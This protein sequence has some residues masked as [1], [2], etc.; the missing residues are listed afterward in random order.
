[1][2]RDILF[3]MCISVLCLCECADT[4]DVVSSLLDSV[5]L[6]CSV[7]SDNFVHYFGGWVDNKKWDAACVDIGLDL[8]WYDCVSFILQYFWINF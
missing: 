4:L 5:I 2:D 7:F 1:M 8:D 3:I 6:L